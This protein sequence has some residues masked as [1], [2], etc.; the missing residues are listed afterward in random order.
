LELGIPFDKIRD[1]LKKF[2]GVGRRLEIKND[3]NGVLYLDDY[4]HHPTEIRATL[5]AIKNNLPDRRLIVIFQP[6][7]YTRTKILYKQFGPVFK[8]ADIVKLMDI[9]PASEKPI[10]GV[11]TKLILN[12]VK[13]YHGHV[14]MFSELDVPSLQKQFR[15]GD[16]VLTLGA[17]SVYKLHDK[18]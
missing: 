3:T 9:Y 11:T 12:E 7:R 13:K 8:S 1:G 14:S 15:P 6:H 17:G 10:P 16:V 5:N 2:I 18:F 4:G